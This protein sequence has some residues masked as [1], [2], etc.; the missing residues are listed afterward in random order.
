MVEE[1][2]EEMVEEGKWKKRS[3]EM[4]EEGT[5]EGGRRGVEMVEEGREVEERGEVE[6]KGKTEEEV[7]RWKKWW[8]R[9]RGKVEEDELRNGGRGD[10][11]KWR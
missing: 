11:G 9:G 10:V 8:K 7:G 4:V 2:V 5:W 6:E 3:E 1:K